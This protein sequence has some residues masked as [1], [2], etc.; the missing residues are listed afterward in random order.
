VRRGLFVV[1]A[2]GS[3]LCALRALC[4]VC[5]GLSSSGWPVPMLISLALLLVLCSNA[6]A[7]H[8]GGHLWIDLVSPGESLI[9][10]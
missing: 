3:L 5:R 4:R 6:L 7:A 8:A 2:E 10:L 9:T 1:R